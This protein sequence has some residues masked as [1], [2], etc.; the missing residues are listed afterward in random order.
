LRAA[1]AL[2]GIDGD[3]NAEVQLGQRRCADRTI[4][5]SG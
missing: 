4:Q 2:V 5:V 3:E 1:P